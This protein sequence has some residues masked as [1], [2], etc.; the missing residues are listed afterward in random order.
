MMVHFYRTSV[1]GPQS[2]HVEWTVISH[3]LWVSQLL[4]RGVKWPAYCTQPVGHIAYVIFLELF[5]D[6]VYSYLLQEVGD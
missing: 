2:F 3:I 6:R 1:F 4:L 5:E